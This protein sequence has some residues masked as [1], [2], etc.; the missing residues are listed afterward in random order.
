MNFLL[1]IKYAVLQVL[2]FPPVKILCGLATTIVSLAFAPHTHLVFVLALFMSVDLIFGVTRA[3]RAHRLSSAGARRAV[4]KFAAYA[5]MV[6]A[7]GLAEQVVTG[8][9]KYLL[10]GVMGILIATELLSLLE[11]LAA[12]GLNFPGVKFVRLWARQ[13][14][15]NYG[16]AYEGEAP[17]NSSQCVD[18]L[19]LLED[20]VPQIPNDQL[21]HSCYIYI[22]EIYVLACD[23]RMY[24]IDDNHTILSYERLCAQIDTMIHGVKDDLLHAGF[25]PRFVEHFME[26][27]L[28]D[29]HRRL[30]HR[31]RVAVETPEL[32]SAVERIRAL[33]GALYHHCFRVYH[34]AK[35]AGRHG[36]NGSELLKSTKPVSDDSDDGSGRLSCKATQQRADDAKGEP[37]E[38]ETAAVQPTAEDATPEAHEAI[39]P[40]EPA[41]GLVPPKKRP[42]GGTTR[43]MKTPAP[44][45]LIDGTTDRIIKIS[46]TPRPE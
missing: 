44:R 38:A 7:V 16:I 31:C 8:S 41:D 1:D 39:N 3:F 15:M 20:N 10:P 21:R 37:P 43:L 30:M 46:K 29:V 36:E 22:R 9:T 19:R 14:M 34:C 45:S 2:A 11:H 33:R 28:F 26:Q 13:K 23:L 40:A 42:K 6:L 25:S 27:W 35:R 4:G 32:T 12:L 5:S 17:E 24:D 18:L